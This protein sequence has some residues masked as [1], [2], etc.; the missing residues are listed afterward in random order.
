[1]TDEG[2]A[3]PRGVELTLDKRMQA[4]VREGLLQSDV[5]KGAAVLLDA[6]N[7]EILALCS[8]PEYDP[9]DVGARLDDPDAPF[10]DRALQSVSVGSVYKIIVAAALL[11]HGVGEGFTYVCTGET[12]QNDV[13]FHCHLRT[14]H[15]ALTMPDA[16]YHSCNTWFIHAAKQIP[17]SGC[18]SY[19][20]RNSVKADRVNLP[21]S[22]T[23]TKKP[24]A[25]ALSMCFPPLPIRKMVG[26]NRISSFQ[27]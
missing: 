14:G 12:V 11:E 16:L 9:S 25:W 15:G 3:S 21:S 18:R 8:V 27:R 23:P 26:I 22:R 17:V 13:T 5:R 2:V 4:A 10:V 24:P 6:E 19:S 7:G 20:V 1:M